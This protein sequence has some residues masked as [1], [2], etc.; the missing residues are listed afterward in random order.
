MSDQ[1]KL[2]ILLAYW[3]RHNLE[4]AEEFREWAQ[5]ALEFGG[6]DVALK[7]EAAAQ[8]MA[9]LNDSLHAALELLGG[10]LEE[11]ESGT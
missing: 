5:R 11:A 7:L 9:D 10:S 8:E 4:H 2:R 6:K 1:E 3:V